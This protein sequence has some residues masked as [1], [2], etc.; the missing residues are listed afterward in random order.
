MS[1]DLDLSVDRTSEVPLGTQLMWK[2]RTLIGTGEL[3]PA[4]R[5]PGIRELAALAGVNI[6]TVRSVVARLEEQGLL[7]THQGRGNFVADSAR[8]D[9]NLAETADAAISQARAAGIDPR[10]L[11]AALYVSRR[12]ESNG[13]A[14]VRRQATAVSVSNATERQKLRTDIERLELRLAQLEPLSPLEHRRSQP[15][16]R[17]L[18]T[19]ELRHTRDAL[20]QRIQE[21]RQQRQDWRVE[22]ERQLAAEHRAVEGSRA[23][24]WGAG[25]WTGRPGADVSW[26][27]A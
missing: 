21:L 18:T 15:Q 22:A 6:N 14:E 2:L 17:V 19:A 3:A 5:L 7:I 24:R 20:T 8:S 23:R 10:E 1:F 9:A 13:L 11:A 26:T 27:T 12:T 16:P 25:V 4:E